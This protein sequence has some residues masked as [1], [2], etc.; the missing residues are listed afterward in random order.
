MI[1]DKNTSR[2]PISELGE[3]GLINHL[4]KN[5]KITQKT[6]DL[7]IGDDA[8]VMDFKGK[9]CVLSTDLL[10]EGVHFDLAY[11]P[12]KHLGYKA[13]IVNL[14]DIYAMNAIA[15]QVTVSIAISNR[16]PLE[17]LEELYAGIETAAK[18]YNIDVVGGDTTSSTTGL[19]ISVTAVGY[20]NKEDLV[21]RSGAADND[22]LVVTGDLGAAYMGLQVLER[23]KQVF[24]V[25]PNSQP[26][27]DRYT[28][29]IERQLKPEARKDIPELLKALDVKPTSMIDISDG[30]SSEVI[31][32]CKQS[33]VGV[34]LYEEKIPLDPAVI[35][36]CEEFK[37]NSTTAALNG[38]EDYE[39]LFTIKQEDYPKIKANPNLT[40]IG[41][42][43]DEKSGIG[44]VTRANEKIE[45]KAQGWNPIKK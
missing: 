8:A 29:L 4:T 31:H 28:Y 3:F 6:T 26:D 2:T 32:L 45:L 27:L 35:S 10:L 39:L 42:M 15:T 19:I 40:V 12:L 13:V 24:E 17:A 21:Y 37:I 33:K 41:H 43:T 20:A 14:S 18:L 7:G 44:L 30:L 22:L 9:K 38:G 34:N 16:F 1:E 11:V 5:F 25:N 36:I 23:E